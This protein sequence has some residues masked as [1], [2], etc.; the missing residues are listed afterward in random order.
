MDYL[1]WVPGKLYQTV[2]TIAASQYLP[3]KHIREGR[4]EFL[5]SVGILMREHNLT[6]KQA[7]EATQTIRNSI[8]VDEVFMLIDG[9]FDDHIFSVLHGGVVKYVSRQAIN[10]HRSVVVFYDHKK[11]IQY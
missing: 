10:M 4:L 5:Y 8:D 1:P 3:Q 11:E 7:I 2:C 6:E 9:H